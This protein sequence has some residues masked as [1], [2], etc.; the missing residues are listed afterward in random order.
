MEAKPGL[1]NKSFTPLLLAGLQSC[2]EDRLDA[3]FVH[4]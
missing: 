3:K 4:P 1:P 2:P